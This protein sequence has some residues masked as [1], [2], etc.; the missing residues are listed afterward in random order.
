MR[1]A[2]A[3]INRLS[4]Y[5]WNQGTTM[6]SMSEEQV[7]EEAGEGVEPMG[8]EAAEGE[9]DGTFYI[10]IACKPD[11][12]FEVGIEDS[13]YETAEE[14]GAE[15]AGLSKPPTQSFASPKEALTAVLALMKGGQMQQP[16]DERAQM[17]AGFN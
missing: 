8:A 17:S 5:G 11:G 10:E 15:N 9:G 1:A 12:T 3:Q 4:P 7:S 16:T 2:F 6:A 14:Q 13:A